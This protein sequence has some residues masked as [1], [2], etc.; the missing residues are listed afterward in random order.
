[1]LEI[2]P[3]SFPFFPVF[4]VN[5]IRIYRSVINCV[6]PSE[7]RT[8]DGFQGTRTESSEMGNA[9]YPVVSNS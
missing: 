3:G 1:M 7:L 8:R 2:M 5:F 9:A 6:W 4:P